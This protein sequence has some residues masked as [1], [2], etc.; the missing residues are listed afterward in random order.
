MLVT[1]NGP[2]LANTVEEFVCS[3]EVINSLGGVSQNK[4]GLGT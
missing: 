1:L 4:I 2:D 3:N